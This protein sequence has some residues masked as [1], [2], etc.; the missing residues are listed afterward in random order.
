[1][2]I[3]KFTAEQKSSVFSVVAGVLYFGNVKFKLESRSTA[4]DAAVISTPE[5]LQH[6]VT[7]WKLDYQQCEKF[8]LAKNIGSREVNISGKI[9]YTLSKY[10][11]FTL[12]DILADR[13]S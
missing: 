10:S 8:L 13:I 7:L 5:V 4:E 2:E 9:V 3:L 11:L 1:M 6:A 12:S